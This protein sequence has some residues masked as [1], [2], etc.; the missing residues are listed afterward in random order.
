MK[1]RYQG[2]PK[3]GI[4]TKVT[5]STFA[6][7]VIDESLVDVGVYLCPVYDN[8]Y[9]DYAIEVRRGDNDARVGYLR[10]VYSFHLQAYAETHGLSASVRGVT[11]GT[12]DKPYR[13]LNLYVHTNDGTPLP[14][15]D[16]MLGEGR[17]AS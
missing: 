4:F 13:G 16:F 6:P 15:K 10:A 14:S 17:R 12:K 3:G 11:G 8:A 7:G 2:L 9:D 5:G 1:G